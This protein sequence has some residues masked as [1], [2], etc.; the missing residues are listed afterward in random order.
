M[1]APSPPG[2]KL[3]QTFF[4]FKPEHRVDLHDNLFN[5]LWHGDGRWDWDMLYNMP[6]FLRKFY[7]KRVNKLIEERN[8][9]REAAIEKAKN[10]RKSNS[11]P[12]SPF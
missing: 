1:E 4:G 9:Q 12:K 2:F 10:K 7:V 11:M 8:A 5:L 6:I 3:D